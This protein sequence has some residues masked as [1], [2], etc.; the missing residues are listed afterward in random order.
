MLNAIV[1]PHDEGVS[2]IVAVDARG[3]A[4]LEERWADRK[5]PRWASKLDGVGIHSDG[6]IRRFNVRR[7]RIGRIAFSM[8]MFTL[9]YHRYAEEV[10]R[11]TREAAAGLP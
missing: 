7:W 10:E 6:S 11:A 5:P 8:P 9:E 3:Q 4:Q 2:L 1:F